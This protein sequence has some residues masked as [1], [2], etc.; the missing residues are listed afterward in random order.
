MGKILILHWCINAKF[1]TVFKDKEVKLSVT[2]TS[3]KVQ[4]QH[5]VIT[6]QQS[7]VQCFNLVDQNSDYLTS[8]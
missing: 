8:L 2:I 3:Y 4:I 5:Y 1:V 6:N 7:V